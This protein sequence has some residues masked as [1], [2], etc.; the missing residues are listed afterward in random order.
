MPIISTPPTPGLFD[1]TSSRPLSQSDTADMLKSFMSNMMS[2]M[3]GTVRSL[4]TEMLASH[5]LEASSYIVT[6]VLGLLGTNS[7]YCFS[8][9]WGTD[10]VYR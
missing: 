6:F 8:D 2:Q 10:S 5:Q 9:C 7:V 4:V 3:K 1:P